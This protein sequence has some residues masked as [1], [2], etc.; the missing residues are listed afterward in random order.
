MGTS[1]DVLLT[2]EEYDVYWCWCGV[3]HEQSLY[4]YLPLTVLNWWWWRTLVPVLKQA[5][6]LL[7]C[8]QIPF[9]LFVSS[10]HVS[11]IV[12]VLKIKCLLLLRNCDFHLEWWQKR[13]N[14]EMCWCS[15]G[16]CV[17]V[18]VCVSTDAFAPLPQC[19]Y[20]GKRLLWPFFCF[21]AERGWFKRG[22]ALEEACI[23]VCV[24][25]FVCSPN[26]HISMIRNPMSDQ[27]VVFPV[28]YMNFR[29][30]CSHF[31]IVALPWCW[32]F[33]QHMCPYNPLSYCYLCHTP[34][35]IK[36]C[37]RLLFFVYS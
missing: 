20:S 27:V 3:M 37:R 33:I 13:P 21:K 22:R 11:W 19:W 17:C 28:V 31:Y 7:I 32:H 2:Q 34:R 5:L 1:C 25:V 14:S 29:Y 26:F 9:D 36:V 6:V 18:C 10:L 23:C 30:L 16:V 24:C 12:W 35:H 4:L 15:N 8:E